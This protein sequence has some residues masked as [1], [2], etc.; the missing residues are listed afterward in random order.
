MGEPTPEQIMLMNLPLIRVLDWLH[1][2]MEE[3]GK[4]KCEFTI[5]F[6]DCKFVITCEEVKDNAESS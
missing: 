6:K 4:G 2:K 5:P 3:H 1:G